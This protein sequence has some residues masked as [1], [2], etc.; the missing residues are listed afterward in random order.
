[1]F[2]GYRLFGPEIDRSAP[3]RYVALHIRP[4]SRLT[5]NQAER[6]VSDDIVLKNSLVLYGKP[7]RRKSTFRN[8][9]YS[10]IID[11]RRVELP[12]KISKKSKSRV[13]QHNM[14][15]S[16]RWCKSC[17]DCAC[18][19]ASNKVCGKA[20]RKQTAE[21]TP[22]RTSTHTDFRIDQTNQAEKLAGNYG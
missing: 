9:P 10:T 15:I 7:K 12:P 13:F 16:G 3:R 14:L 11:I 4:I 19:T 22:I 17:V 2:I 21:H 5:T 20:C 1:M 6:Q 18:C 8:A